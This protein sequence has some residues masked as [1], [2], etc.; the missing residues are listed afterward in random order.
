MY[1]ITINGTK[2]EVPEGLTLIQVC[3]IYNIKIPRF[4]YHEKLPSVGNCRMCLVELK[5]SP[6][7]VSSCTTDV[8]DGMEILT[9][10]EK[11]DKARSSMLEM[12]LV[13]HPLDCP[14]C[15]KGGECD[16]QDQT[17][18]YGLDRS[19]I[20][21]DKRAV[22]TKSFGPLIDSYMTRCILCT[23]CIRFATEIAGVDELGAIGRNA[24]TEINTYIDSTITS[25]L[26][27]NLVDVC[28]VGALTN[29]SYAF[30]AR[31]WETISTES[32]DIMD[33]MGSNITINSSPL[34]VLRILPRLNDSINQEWIGDKSRYV[35]DSFR[36]QRLDYPMV[37]KN[38]K[39]EKT[40]WDEAFK[41]IKSHIKKCQK[42][43]IASIAGN[44][45]DV[46]TMYSMKKLFHLLNSKLIECRVNGVNYDVT[47]R[48]HYL[49][50]S[51]IAGI[52]KS[53]SCLIVG[54]NPR[55][56]APVLNARI[57]KRYLQ[58]DYT[59]GLIG[60]KEKLTYKTEYLG[61]NAE[62]LQNILDDKS[63]FCDVLLN[64]KKPMI[65]VGLGA[66][67][68]ENYHTTMHLIDK[69]VQKYPNLISDNWNGINILHT[70]ISEIS[71]L[72]VGFTQTD[73]DKSYN[74]IITDT[75]QNKIKVLWL[76]NH[77]NINPSHVHKNTFIIYQGHHGDNGAQMASVILPSALW[78]EKS[79]LY[80]N[81][82]GKAQFTQK[83]I[84][85]IGDAKEDWRIIRKIAE[86][87]ELDLGFNTRS[88]LLKEI[89]DSYGHIK[90]NMITYA[91]FENL[92]TKKM[93]NNTN[94]VS[95]LSNYYITDV[96][97]KNSNK[98]S[99]IANILYKKG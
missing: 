28:P 29:S 58:G 64:S 17:Y 36:Q 50:N 7:L 55:I 60:K 80:I 24:S 8:T 84:P 6:K 9:E 77:D 15:D 33:A 92:K 44:F 18:K 65:I 11:I 98:M 47:N 31:P 19:T 40:T 30:K 83:A 52:D 35:V 27:G 72:E 88:E 1:N 14:I 82:E 13:N 4:C 62:A 76:L 69:I 45:V 34:A 39:L 22:P 78:V 56:E 25:E 95:I 54:S 97:S 99:E 49:F 66:L 20:K 63:M 81:M 93:L 79:S 5:G 26:S 86:I 61:V 2:Y 90:I 94:F 46:E 42:D 91:N 96:I 71:G 70:S 75:I 41:L 53:D 3:D 12:I 16:L 51:T 59:I 67:Q 73:E 23:R 38:G 85:T 89:F 43:E 21:I 68:N 48:S 32:I 57:R 87:L 37:R 10:S 74:S